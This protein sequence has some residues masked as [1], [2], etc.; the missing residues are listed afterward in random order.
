MNDIDQYYFEST[1]NNVTQ[2][3]T[4]L[5]MILVW[6]FS[7]PLAFGV[8]GGGAEAGLGLTIVSSAIAVGT[9]ATG[10]TVTT[11][12]RV[13][14]QDTLRSIEALPMLDPKT[15]SRSLYFRH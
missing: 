9:L 13:L 11:R 12:Y 14:N 6:G 15:S 5:I 8:L 7:I 2:F 3:V 10:N 4:F 1:R